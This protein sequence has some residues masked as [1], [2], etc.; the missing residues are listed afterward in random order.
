MKDKLLSVSDLEAELKVSE[1]IKS[2]DVALDGSAVFTL[3]DGW[4]IGLKEKPGRALTEA[5]IAVNGTMYQLEKDAILDISSSMGI[6]REYM[7]KTPGALMEPH[8]NYWGASTPTKA[9]RLLM[10]GDKVTAFTKTSVVPFSNLTLLET[11]LA[12]LRKK[13]GTHVEVL[14]DYKRHHDADYTSY[15]LIVPESQRKI[16]S[17]RSDADIWSVGVDVRN[18]LTGKKP[19]SLSGYLFAWWCTNGA[20]STHATSGNYNRKT[21]GQDQ[22]EAMEWARLSVDEILGGLEHEFDAVQELT[23][24]SLGEDVTTTLQDIFTQYRVPLKQREGIIDRV[25]DS[26]D[27]TMYGIMAAITEGANFDGVPINVREAL[28]EIGGDLPATASSR[29]SS[30]KRLNIH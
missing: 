28:M 7:M 17:A 21:S 22:T 24:V 11:V 30:C 8:V 3:P 20:I 27:L 4:N 23:T 13:Y 29:C 5:T 10:A 19:L 18:S 9:M 25:L 2:M 1:P 16:T 15:R 6:T 26:D 12:E 14:V